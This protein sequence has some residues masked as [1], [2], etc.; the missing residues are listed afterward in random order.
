[1]VVADDEQS[2]TCIPPQRLETLLEQ[3]RVADIDRARAQAAQLLEE[4]N[5]GGGPFA[6]PTR[7]GCCGCRAVARWRNQQDQVA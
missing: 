5:R 7:C 6:H 2:S 4:I 3:R 1:M